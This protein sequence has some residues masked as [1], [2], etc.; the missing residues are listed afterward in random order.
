MG[1]QS[2]TLRT[3]GFE[4]ALQAISKDLK[5]GHVEIYPGHLAGM[6]PPQ[7]MKKLKAAGVFAVAYGVVPFSKDTEKTARL[8]ELAKAFGMKNLTLR[9]RPRR[10][11]QPR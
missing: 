10:L 11:R 5:L 7:A 1:V 3:M 4:K 8:F 2:Y 9:P 6:S